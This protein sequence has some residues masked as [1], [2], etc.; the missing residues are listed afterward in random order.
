MDCLDE[1]AEQLGGWSEEGTVT[2]FWDRVAYT[3]A[4]LT[5]PSFVIWALE[6]RLLP[7]WDLRG[8][9]L[10]GANLSGA[11]LSGANLSGANLSRANLSG[12]LNTDLAYGL[13]KPEPKADGATP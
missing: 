3:W 6:E 12:A 5:Y 11:D 4:L 10:S 7:S 9:N 1:I 2:L 13:P 8:A